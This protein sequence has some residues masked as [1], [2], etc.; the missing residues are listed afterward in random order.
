M[1]ESK[2]SPARKLRQLLERFEIAM[3]VSRTS[4]GHLRARPMAIARVEDDCTL[5]FFTSIE[6]GK[7]H[8]IEADPHVSVVCQK[9]ADLYISITGHATLD[10]RPEQIRALW[11]EAYRIWFTEGLDNGEIALVS[12]RPVQGEYW[13]EGGFNKIKYLFE[14]ARAHAMGAT[15]HPQDA[16][17]HAKVWLAAGA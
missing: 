15:P 8:E 1:S 16:E 5:W 14:I 11:S 12:V 13:D 6:S 3:L 17:E 7:V 9:G 4:G 10:R 2:L